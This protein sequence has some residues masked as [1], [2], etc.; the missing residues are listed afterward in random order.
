MSV[1]DEVPWIKDHIELYKT[2]PEKAHYFTVP[3]T[4][5]KA[6]PSLLLTT[7]GRKSGAPRDITVFY[8]KSGD[9]FIIVASLGGAPVHPAWY[10][11]LAAHPEAEI[12]VGK[13]HYVVTARDAKGEERRKFLQIMIDDVMERYADYEQMTQGVREMPV[14][15]LEP[16]R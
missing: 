14:V 15:V 8:G 12:Q 3:G 10:N 7:I 13:D 11:N 9:K 4:D 5:G 6:R 2:D 16:K 1:V